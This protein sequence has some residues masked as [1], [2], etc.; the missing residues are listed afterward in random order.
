ML[1]RYYTIWN[2]NSRF[3]VKSVLLFG[4]FIESTSKPFAR[5]HKKPHF[6]CFT[7]PRGSFLLFL[8][9]HVHHPLG[10]MITLW[11]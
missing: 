8:G 1:R 10:Q 5:A 11:P 7:F 4:E 6:Y 9:E 3:K 2:I